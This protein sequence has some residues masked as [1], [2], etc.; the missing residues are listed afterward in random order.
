MNPIKRFS[1]R[2]VHAGLDCLPE[3]A[4]TP[5]LFQTSAF[6]FPSAEE[7]V[8]RFQQEEG[9]VYSRYG[10]PT[11]HAVEQRLASL[12]ES[13]DA[14]LCSSGM[15]AITCS[16]LSLLQVG[17]HLISEESVYGGTYSLFN[18]LFPRWG[19]E[20]TW[21]NTL[22][23]DAIRKALRASTR[24]LYLETPANPRL[25]VLPLSDLARFAREEDLVSIV[26]S[27]FG[28]PYHQLPLTMGCDMVIHSATKFLGGHGD[29]TAG[30]VASNHAQIER[31]RKQYHRLMGGMLSPFEAFLLARGLQTLPLRMERI[32]AT[33][34][35]LAHFLQK[36]PAV[37]Y[38][39]YPGLE[40]HPQHEIACQ[41][42]RNG[43]GGVLAF[44][45]KEGF[46]AAVR[47]LDSLQLILRAAS[48]GDV[49]TLIMH[50]ASSSHRALP[51][52]ER[53]VLGIGDGLLRLSVGLEDPIDLQDDLKQA[54]SC[55]AK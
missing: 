43:F 44:E 33:A 24:V 15:F 30:V 1:T 20:V 8:R 34:L 11:V 26:D 51:P 21:V 7:G 17:D 37:S 22:D 29:L 23:A 13:E 6:A 50:P 47:F 40:S 46:A 38:V 49:T 41:Q 42:M 35:T 36:E 19:I 2:A 45:M 39:H 55:I 54:F 28:T 14:L 10:N 3:G 32:S 4:T 12:E 53:R 27:T 16:L 18:Q 31:V 5:P 25:K 9:Y 52:E 48:L